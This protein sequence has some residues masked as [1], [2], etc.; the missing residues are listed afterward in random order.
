MSHCRNSKKDCLPK[1]QRLSLPV[2]LMTAAETLELWL[3]PVSPSLV[4]SD[5]L[6]PWNYGKIDMLP[7]AY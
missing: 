5:L 6:V 2:S 4:S 3:P 1:N 7:D